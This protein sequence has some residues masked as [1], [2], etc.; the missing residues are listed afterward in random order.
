M[1]RLPRIVIPGLPHW[2]RLPPFSNGMGTLP[3][4]LVKVPQMKRKS[5]RQSETTGRLLGSAEWMEVLEKMK[6]TVLKPQKRGP[7]KRDS[8]DR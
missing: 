2:Q 8:N 4:S 5:L 7:K 6:G 3:P 1:A